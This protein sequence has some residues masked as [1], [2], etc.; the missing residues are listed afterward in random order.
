MPDFSNLSGISSAAYTDYAAKTQYSNEVQKAV[1]KAPTSE[2]EKEL[3][4][5]CKKFEAYFL[6]QVFKEMS[7]TVDAFKTDDSQ[8][9][10]ALSMTSSNS[11][12]DYFKDLTIQDIA[13]TA[14]DNQSNG[15]AQMLYE[16]MKRTYGIGDEASHDIPADA[17]QAQ[18]LSTMSSLQQATLEKEASENKAETADGDK[19]SDIPNVGEV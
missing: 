15:L 8:M 17:S 9:S 11:L 12:V 4:D 13:S 3:M 19:E 14:A 5:A 10:D 1:E 7:K 6:E 2:T 16:N 18:V